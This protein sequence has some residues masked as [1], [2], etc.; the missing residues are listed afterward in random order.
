MKNQGQIIIFVLLS[1]FLIVFILSSS[2]TFYYT[3]LKMVERE[4]DRL[5]ALN[6]AESGLEYVRW[7]LNHFPT[8]YTLGVSTPQPYKYDFYDRLGNKIGEY[9]ITIIPPATGTTVVKVNSTGKVLTSNFKRSLSVIMAKPSIAKYAALSDDNLR[10][11]EGTVVYGEIH[12]NK[13]IRFDG[14]AYNLVKSSLTLY[15][16]P[17]HPGCQEWAVHT[18]VNP[19]DPC[20]PP[21]NPDPSLLPFRPDVFKAGR[22]VGV[23][24][25]DFVGISA[26]LS[27]LK[28]KAL[29]NGFYLEFSGDNNYG[30]ELIL[31]ENN[32]DVYKVTK[33]VDVPPNCEI[34]DTY[35]GQA[36]KNDRYR[37]NTWSIS[38][39]Q[40]V[41]TFNYPPNN[42]IFV[43]DNVWVSGRIKGR[44]LTIASAKFPEST[45]QMT[46]III[47]NDLRLTNYD[48]SESI[49]LIAQKNINVGLKSSDILRIDAALIAQNGRVGRYY[50]SQG[51]GPEYKREKIT[52]YGSIA[53]RFRYGFS[54]VTG[55]TWSSG[56]RLRELIYDNNLL[57]FAPPYFPLS[58]DFY[59]ILKWQEK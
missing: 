14:V 26:N 23:P 28:Q 46:N 53:S 18:H 8:D 39:K 51:C 30:Y 42:I 40:F 25:V 50:Y 15:N 12:S 32:F 1:F 56:Y 41:G 13:G 31:K 7:Y 5:R 21:N 55:N 34:Y 16:D 36:D 38:R 9:E 54:W 3:F 57:Y 11:G 27:D 20:P 37:H 22:E 45:A 17:D 19:Q 48:G 49:G 2:L 43:E 58:G 24:T 4:R 6:I 47:N 52:I 44:R 59:Q 35:E 29:Q 10:F 33:V